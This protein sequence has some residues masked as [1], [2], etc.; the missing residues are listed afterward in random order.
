MNSFLILS[1]C[2]QSVIELDFEPQDLCFL[3]LQS[4]KPHKLT[5]TIPA[6]IPDEPA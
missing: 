4:D 5:L 2:K 1:L 6:L 3:I